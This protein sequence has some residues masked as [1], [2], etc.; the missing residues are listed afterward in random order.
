MA[1]DIA[2]FTD[3]DA[4]AADAGGALDREQQKRL[5]DRISWFQRLHEY[6]AIPGTPLIVRAR[7]GE[8]AAWLFLARQSRRKATALANWYSLET[9]V[10]THGVTKPVLVTALGQ[11]LKALGLGVI[12]ISPIT[13]D[14]L[15]LSGEAFR[16]AGWIARAESVTANWSIAPPDGGWDGYLAG[17][18]SRLRN[19]IRRKSGNTQLRIIQEF[20]NDAWRHYKEIYAES[21]KPA[22]GSPAFLQSLAESEGSAGTLRIGL[23]LHKGKAVAA[24]VWLV[25]N[26]TATIHKLAHVEGSSAQSAGTVLT[27]AMFRHVIEQDQVTRI[28]FGV[29]DDRYKADWMDE[30]RPLYQL[31]LFNPST[32]DGLVG[33]LRE[34]LSAAR[35][36]I[37]RA[38]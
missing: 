10:V 18:P 26:G 23:A 16:A 27:A 17:R 14:R 38:R 11:H 7:D 5:F 22:E 32:I 21:W 37:R 19:M 2:S 1:I 25:E 20:D 9:G 31:R 8:G 12:T 29:G 35:A 34:R 36:G 3:L 6:C 24:Q 28:D 13:E 33:V 30:R 4:V 15:S